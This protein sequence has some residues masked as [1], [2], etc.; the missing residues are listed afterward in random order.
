MREQ[1]A[2][3]ERRKNMK[4][5]IVTLDLHGM[6]CFQAKT[7]LDCELRRAGGS[8]YRLRVIHGY[9]NGN[10]LKSLVLSYASHPKVRRL[11]GGGNPGQTDLVLRELY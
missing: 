5:G 6:N 1:S 3:R 8:V 4:S 9:K 2:E 7:A 10:E 11:Q